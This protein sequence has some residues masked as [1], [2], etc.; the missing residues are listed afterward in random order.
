MAQAEHETYPRDDRVPGQERG[1]SLTP[2]EAADAAA[3]LLRHADLTTREV[4]VINVLREH[5]RAT[6]V[7]PE[8]LTLAD[9]TQLRFRTVKSL[10]GGTS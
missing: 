10:A 5:A 4:E 6:D 1:R 9:G 3:S 2:R 8:H 7:E